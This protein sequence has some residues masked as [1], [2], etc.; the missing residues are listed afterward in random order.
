M[1]WILFLSLLLAHRPALSPCQLSGVPDAARCGTYEVFENRDSR[2][3]RKI[4]LNVA[5][6]PALGPDRLP[7]PIVFFDGGPGEATIASADWIHKNLQPLRRHRDILLVDAR[8]TGR[9]GPLACEESDA[10]RLQGFLDDF[11][12][13]DQ[14]RACRDVLR[15]RA[16][17][18]Q[19]TTDRIVDDMA[20]V[21]AALGYQTLNLMGSSYGTRAA[22]V[23]LRRHP[24]RVHTATIF[25]V[26][27][28][29]ARVP[30]PAAQNTQRALDA[31]FAEC[32]KDRACAAA[33]P[34]LRA[35]LAAVLRRAGEKPVPVAITD[36]DTEKKVSIVLSREGVAQT[37]RYMLYADFGAARL[38]LALHRAAGGDFQ[39]LG[40]MAYL[41]ANG[42]TES[43]RGL[44]LSVTCA[45]DVA[46][47]RE[48]EI[49]SAT[50]GTFL[51]D[52]R[53]R[54]QIAACQEWPAAHIEP[55]FLDPVVSG[56]PVLA[57]SGERDPTTPPGNGE[58]VVSHLKRG[59]LLV[60]PHKGHGVVGAAGSDCVVGVI[61]QFLDAGSA[62]KLDVSCVQKIPAAEFVL[63]VPTTPPAPAAPSHALRGAG[64]ATSTGRASGPE[65]AV[66]CRGAGGCT[67]SRP[68][69]ASGGARP[70]GGGGSREG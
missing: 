49:P 63:G 39:V 19:Y 13:L 35:D 69:R 59:R 25:G 44:Y 51:G 56:A 55:N 31:L 54:R 36:P 43:A 30:L 38:P 34:D 33:F 18:T 12:P 58:Q 60:V 8:G 27:P 4:A 9:S 67:G 10:A 26:L 57:I 23:F 42:V 5:V 65:S 15:K 7:D 24:E 48:D 52:F 46:F 14:V 28:T 37:L 32:A 1:N 64:R 50:A 68:D 41:F 45:E 61:G 66:P 16:D 11:M 21:S 53:I 17:L 47:I 22:L 29:G 20:E 6:L 3:G 70:S 2:K 40:E 62:E